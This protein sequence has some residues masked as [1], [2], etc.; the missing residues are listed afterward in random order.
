MEESAMKEVATPELLERIQYPHLHSSDKHA[1]FFI[2]ADAKME[3]RKRIDFP[4]I[5]KHQREWSEYACI[6]CGQ[7]FT[8]DSYYRM[9]S[10]FD[11]TRCTN[12][13]C[14]KK[15]FCGKTFDTIDGAYNHYQKFFCLQYHNER[16]QAIAEREQKKEE[17]K[18]KQKEINANRPAV[19]RC[20]VCNVEFRCKP[21]EDRHMNGK[22]HLNKVNGVLKC[23]ICDIVVT[24]K[25]KMEVHKATRK[26]QKKAAA[27]ESIQ[28]VEVPTIQIHSPNHTPSQ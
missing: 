13:F 25:A 10:H 19:S 17:Y 26:H 27:Q 11:G 16:Q 1:Q 7:G 28:T 12:G 2:R 3:L 8:V 24:T 22:H 20:D 6:H 21:E 14:E 5:V 9:K 18:E 15:C 23:N 4:H